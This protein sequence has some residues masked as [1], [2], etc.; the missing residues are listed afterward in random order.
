MAE[1]HVH[2]IAYSDFIKAGN[3]LNNQA[4]VDI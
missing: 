2:N 3:L 4:S 1:F